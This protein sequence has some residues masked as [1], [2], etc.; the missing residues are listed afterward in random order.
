MKPPRRI[1]RRGAAAF[2]LAPPMMLGAPSFSF[3]MSVLEWPR[4]SRRVFAYLVDPGNGF[5][6][7]IR[8][9]SHELGAALG[10]G[11]RAIDQALAWLESRGVIR[12]WRRYGHREHA[13]RVI[14]IIIRDH[15]G[16]P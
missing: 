4:A 8:I 2:P 5:G 16:L 7:E 13:G 3:L 10:Y 12:R 6:P 11:I 14:E 15:E 9:T 1:I